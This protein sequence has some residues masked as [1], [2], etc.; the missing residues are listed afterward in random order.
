[1]LRSRPVFW[2]EVKVESISQEFESGSEI[3]AGH[4]SMLLQTRLALTRD[5]ESPMMGYQ[6]SRYKP[7][8]KT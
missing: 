5:E 8:Q 2:V 4:S 6:L 1:M 7:L 3:T